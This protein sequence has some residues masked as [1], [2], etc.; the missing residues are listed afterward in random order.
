MNYISSITKASLV[1]IRTMN[2]GFDMLISQRIS[3]LIVPVVN[4]TIKENFLMRYYESM[5]VDTVTT[6]D[7]YLWL[8]EEYTPYI[9]Q[10]NTR[11]KT[12]KYTEKWKRLIP[13]R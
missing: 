12:L 13:T 10:L 5:Y 3:T 6:I 7:L 9:E 1:E 4:S 11:I 8:E 2:Q